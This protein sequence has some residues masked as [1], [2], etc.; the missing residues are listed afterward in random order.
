M[1]FSDTYKTIEAESRGLFRDRGSRFIAIARPVSSQEEIK[2]ILEELRKEYHDARHHCYAWMLSPDRQSWR[3]ND[4]GEPSGTAGRPVMGQINSR[5][6]TNILVVVIRYFGG[7][8]LGVSGLI[9]AYR[10]AA[11]DA[12][13][14]ARIVEKYV[15][16]SWLVTFQYTSMNDV[17]RVL[18]EEGCSQH[19][20][21]YTGEECSAEISFRASH[22]EIVT[23]RLRKIPGL[24][25]SWLRTG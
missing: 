15:T 16:E 21:N 4:D 20:H 18:K 11:E 7:T 5:E 13:S 25:L 1:L 22:S 23:G 24:S 8:L 6:L 12:L 2:T 10:S 19:S 14:N 17:M 9:N 3:V